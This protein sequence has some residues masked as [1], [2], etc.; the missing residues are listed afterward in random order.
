MRQARD[1][2]AIDTAGGTLAAMALRRRATFASRADA[3]AR[4]TQK[5]PMA[6]M[7][8]EAARLF[9]QH[10]TRPVQQQQQQ[11]QQRQQHTVTSTASEQSRQ[12]ELQQQVELVCEPSVESAYYQ[13]LD[14]PPAVPLAGPGCPLLMLV[15]S[16]PGSSAAS[17]STH[18]AVQQWLLQNTA[19]QARQQAASATPAATG[20]S[21]GSS[22]S[23]SSSS[24]GSSAD[25]GSALHAVLSV[26]NAE[27]ACSL[28]SAR[29]VE[30]AGVSHFGPLEQPQLLAGMAAAFFQ[31]HLLQCKL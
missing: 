15:A 23:G 4:L 27:L 16:S 12:H 18:A 5:P 1:S 31:Q 7:H 28:P 19:R 17:H 22:S 8:P 14:P 3:L 24:H 26:L 13:A 30:V 11:Q 20:S 25:A 21:N 29:L 6:A 9:V 10:G 2:G